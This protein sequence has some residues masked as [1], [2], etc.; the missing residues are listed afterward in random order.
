MDFQINWQGYYAS[1]ANFVLAQIKGPEAALQ[2][3][4]KVQG[5]SKTGMTFTVGDIVASCAHP[6]SDRVT[7]ETW[8]NLTKIRIEGYLSRLTGIAKEALT[9]ATLH[10]LGPGIIIQS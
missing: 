5:M 8:M 7:H 3:A 6:G 9:M 2:A 1:H 4:L 10:T